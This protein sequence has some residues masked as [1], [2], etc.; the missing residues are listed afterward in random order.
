MTIG[1]TCAHFAMFA[2][3]ASVLIPAARAVDSVDDRNALADLYQAMG[4]AQWTNNSN[5]LAP[6]VSMC[7]WYGVV[8]SP[9]DGC[10]S[11]GGTSIECRVAELDLGSNSLVGPIAPAVQQ[12]V[13]LTKLVLSG[14]VLGGTIPNFGAL[15]SLEWLDLHAAQLTGSIP[16]FET[17]VNLRRLELYENQLEGTLPTLSHSI[18]L[19][20]LDV[21]P[22]YGLVGTIPSLFS[23]FVQMQ[24]LYL[25]GNQFTGHVPA[26]E[27]LVKLR[28]L[29]LSSNRL[30][31]TVPA[32]ATLTQL[33]WLGLE[34]NQLTGTVPAFETLT[35]L[36]ILYLYDNLLSG[37]VPAFTTL[38]QLQRLGLHGNSLSGTVPVFTTL[39]Q[40]LE[41]GLQNNRLE[42]TVPVFTSLTQ[43]QTLYL[44]NNLLIGT[45][46][47]FEAITLLQRLDLSGNLLSGTLPTLSFLSQLTALHV[48]RNRLTGSLPK[49]WRMLGYLAV[50]DVADNRLG[51]Q[52]PFFQ[53]GPLPLLTAGFINL[54]FNRFG[55]TFGELPPPELTTLDIRGNQWLCP[56]PEFA[57]SLRM[58]RS[59]CK[60]DW[61]Q[62]GTYAGVAT[63][64]AAV[65]IALFVAIQ[66]TVSEQRVYMAL[67]LLSWFVSAT[68]VVSDAYS[69]TAIVGFLQT[70]PN[71]CVLINEERVFYPLLATYR[72]LPPS[73]QHVPGSFLFS[74][75]IQPQPWREAFG[76]G[77][78]VVRD[79][80]DE[81]ASACR[82]ARE[83]EYDD[84]L[85]KCY[86]AHSNLSTSGGGAHQGFLKTVFTFIAIRAAYELFCLVVIVI[87]CAR[88]SLIL[89]CR[90]W[91]KNS[92][93]LPMLL[94]RALTRAELLDDFVLADTPPS[95]YIWE[96]L[97]SGVFVTALKLFAQTYYLLHVAETGLAFSNWLSLALGLITVV[98]LIGQAAWSWRKMHRD[99]LLEEHY[100]ERA[101]SGADFD[102]DEMTSGG[103]VDMHDYVSM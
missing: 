23:T 55:G 9:P 71:N 58:L 24:I 97:T 92:I 12:L 50:V 43:L 99:E 52:I 103:S 69:Y 79:Y 30:T 4:G 65:G 47:N 44:H 41:L 88:N 25:S 2:A 16:E 18:R 64:V 13:N 26:F 20:Y 85:A 87:S 83:C 82:E 40:L 3:L 57:T 98:R 56:Y 84:T 73:L 54:S 11:T 15:A 94:L 42:G 33:N 66:R 14:N 91:I 61:V 59:E 46:P 77:I 32:F 62:L 102:L 101:A 48:A 89:S 36:T 75:W 68:S 22:C 70:R 74:E 93:F 28:K 80:T 76:N 17:L 29:S 37:T 8:C 27:A 100:A 60:N 51:G 39:T 81:F 86:E 35:Q 45:V 5:W 31:G 78:V 49:S 7:S 19:E 10:P 95:E 6:D 1:S 72:G 90:V 53:H 67:F 21:A 34:I 96:L 38:T 63:G